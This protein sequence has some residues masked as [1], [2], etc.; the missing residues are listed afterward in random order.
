ME[1]TVN[2]DVRGGIAWMTIA[3]EAKAN[4]LSRSMLRM[5][6]EQLRRADVDQAVCAILITSE[7]SRSFSAGMDINEFRGLDP[8]GAYELIDELGNVCE[9]IRTHRKPII[10]AI[11]GYC[12]GGAMEMCIAADLR[13]ASTSSTFVMPEIQLGIP[14]VLDSISLADYIGLALAKEM[15]LTGD[16]VDAER[17]FARGFIN[18]LV[19]VDEVEA[20]AETLARSI[21]KNHPL[22]IEQQKRLFHTWSNTSMN[23]AYADS[24]KE[25]SLAFTTDIPESKIS[26]R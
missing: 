19:E 2:Y 17:M 12:I 21:I 26:S 11:K 20:K 24:K 23:F 25:F 4:C 6:T 5:M 22:V 8:R 15:L 1:G 10:M 9:A 14:S 3:N 7:G 16:P 18:A 13:I